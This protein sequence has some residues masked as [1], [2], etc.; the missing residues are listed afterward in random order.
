MNSDSVSLGI[1]PS[2]L[3][4]VKRVTVQL[5]RECDEQRELYLEAL[6]EYAELYNQWVAVGCPGEAVP[7]TP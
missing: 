1:L 2:T 5:A 3:E 6:A 4:G 7:P